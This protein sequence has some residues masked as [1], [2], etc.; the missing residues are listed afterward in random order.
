MERM[1]HVFSVD[2]PHFRGHILPKDP[3]TQF[4]VETEIR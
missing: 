2:D 1:F 3:T 4:K